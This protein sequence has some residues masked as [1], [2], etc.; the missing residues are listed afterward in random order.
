MGVLL[1]G[2]DPVLEVALRARLPEA[3][4]IT[5]LDEVEAGAFV[6]HQP[7]RDPLE[8]PRQVW[9]LLVD[10]G[11][12]RY[13]Q[14]ST[15]HLMDRHDAGWRITERFA[16][17]PGDDEQLLGAHLSELASR[18]IA[19]SRPIATTV[20]R[21]ADVVD[22]EPGWDE[23]HAE[24]AAEAI[25]SALQ[26]EPGAEEVG[27]WTVLHVSAGNGRVPNVHAA[28][29][30]LEFRP[31]HP[32]VETRSRPRPTMIETHWDEPVDRPLPADEVVAL[33][34]AAGAIGGPTSVALAEHARVIQIDNIP[35]DEWTQVR[36]QGSGVRPAVVLPA[37]H[38]Q[39]ICDVRDGEAVAEV[40]RGASAVVWMTVVRHDPAQA[41]DVNLGGAL[42]VLRAAHEQGVSRVVFCGPSQHLRDHPV[43][44]AETPGVRDDAP[45]RPGDDLYFLTQFL[46]QE[47]LRILAQEWDLSGIIVLFTGLGVAEQPS[48]AH[49]RAAFLTHWDDAGRAIA[50]AAR[51]E[52]L[53]S[54]SPTV[55][56]RARGP[57]GWYPRSQAETLLGWSH[58]NDMSSLWWHPEA[59]K[60]S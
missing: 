40:M 15:L 49:H 11:P 9:H 29:G 37:P 28:D 25:A 50:A 57:H 12:A 31:T 34:G 41:W 5:A 52:H 43:G 6:V 51:A 33:Y 42:R 16:P 24:D 35:L 39:R 19:R 45:P 27:S 47:S 7:P 36:Q 20:L 58:E 56:P 1:W 2:L 17:L 4:T 23:V 60:R 18:E 8:G 48:E 44:Y 26:I 3:R 30:P 10:R 22:H 46:A 53:P 14:L 21:L 59:E 38:E 54:H 13:V 32:C 55:E